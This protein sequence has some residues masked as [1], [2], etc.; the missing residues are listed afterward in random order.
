MDHSKAIITM[1]SFMR[2]CEELQAGSERG[3]EQG[4][5]QEQ[6]R[7][8]IQALGMDFE[9]SVREWN[10]FLAKQLED[11]KARQQQEEM[12]EDQI[13]VVQ[14]D[15]EKLLGVKSPLPAMKGCIKRKTFDRHRDAT[16][17]KK[18]IKKAKELLS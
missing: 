15:I 11:Q 13:R 9:Q 7:L 8:L 10:D 18:C 17:S 1:S 5:A 16:W 4:L 12:I 6:R 2:R 3:N 14:Q